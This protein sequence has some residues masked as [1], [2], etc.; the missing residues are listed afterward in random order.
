MLHPGLL[1]C[2]S[3]E[4]AMSGCC[5]WCLRWPV[6]Q[7]C[8]AM[9]RILPAPV[10]AVLSVCLSSRISLPPCVCL[11]QSLSSSTPHPS[12][13]PSFFL[14]LISLPSHSLS[15]CLHISSN[16]PSRSGELRAQ[17]LKSHPKRT[18]SLR[19]LPLKSGVGQ[20]I[21]MHARLTA[22]D[23]FLPSFYSFS[24]FTCIFSKPSPKFFLC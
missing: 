14:P 24:P 13:S 7:W 17:K 18:Q 15:L 4:V 23:F 2:R 10:S 6:L 19:V 9:L 12:L 16:P 3:S 20:Y 21:A 5:S 8:S 22:R 11:C 1:S